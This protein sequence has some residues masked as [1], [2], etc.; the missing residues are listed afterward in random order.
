[1]P[2]G[3]T[4]RNTWFAGSPESLVG[5]LVRDGVTGVAGYV[6]EPLLNAT[7]RPQILFPAYLAGF[8]LVEA[9]YLA[10]PH[11]G[12]QAVVIGDPLCSPFARK[13]LSRSEIEDGLDDVTMMPAL[14]AKRRLT[15]EM[16]R[17]GDTPEK[18]VALTLRATA[19]ALTGDA[20]AARATLDEALAIAPRYVPA[21]TLA[22]NYDEQAGRYAPANERYRRIL[23]VQPN[24]AVALNNLAYSLAV[25]MKMP[26]EALPLARRAVAQAPTNVALLDTLGWIQHLV[27]DDASAVTVMAQVARANLPVAS[28]RL[29]TAIVFAAQGVRA[30]AEN[31]LAAAVKLNP[32]LEKTDEVKQLRAKLAA[33]AAPTPARP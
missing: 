3:D 14:F 31:E 5:D 24:N 19:I 33:P 21:L 20:N 9:Y 29:H 11:L 13:A 32:E 28:I 7:V 2:T 8:N 17:S 12:W 1:V 25:N 22:A 30:V 16:A 6:T 27:G 15:I 18:A 4:N 26:T 10:L 23:E